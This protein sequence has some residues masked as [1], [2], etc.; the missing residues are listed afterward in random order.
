[1]TEMLNDLSGLE[2]RLE[3]TNLGDDEDENESDESDASSDE[4]NDNKENEQNEE[5]QV[6]ENATTD[7]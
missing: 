2:D 7:K 5:R 1:M 3:K 4:N 6:S